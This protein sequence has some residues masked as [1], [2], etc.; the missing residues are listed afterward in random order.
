MSNRCPLVEY[1]FPFSKREETSEGAFASPS[2]FVC[3][4]R[5]PIKGVRKRALAG[6]AM[7]CASAMWRPL[8]YP[9]ERASND[10]ACI[11]LIYVADATGNRFWG[12]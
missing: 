1:F 3:A 6:R 5:G 12:T 10:V 4:I 2:F 11:K 7:L 9:L 8:L